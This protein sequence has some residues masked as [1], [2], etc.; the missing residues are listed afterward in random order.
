VP[1]VNYKIN[2]GYIN[3]VSCN[4]ECEMGYNI[5]FTSSNKATVPYNTL[6]YTDIELPFKK[7]HHFI[8][9]YNL[10]VRYIKQVH[11]QT[12]DDALKL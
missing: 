1:E 3:V 4:K 7:N 6:F 5:F 12:N 10:L 8:Y 11:R 9:F 2:M